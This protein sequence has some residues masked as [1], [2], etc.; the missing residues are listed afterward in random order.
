MECADGPAVCGAAPARAE[1]SHVVE[2][3]AG[4]LA[5][6]GHDMLTVVSK[7]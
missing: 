7:C 5:A 6:G 1:P 2:L 3:D 4:T